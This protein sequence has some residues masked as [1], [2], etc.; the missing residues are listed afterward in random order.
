MV[1]LPRPAKHTTTVPTTGPVIHH[2]MRY[3]H[4]RTHQNG[5]KVRRTRYGPAAYRTH[6]DNLSTMIDP[7]QLGFLALVVII[8]W[9]Q[10]VT[11]FDDWRFLIRGLVLFCGASQT[12]YSLSR[13]ISL[14]H[15]PLSNLYESLIFLSW[16]LT[17]CVIGVQLDLPWLTHRV[18]RLLQ[19]GVIDRVPDRWLPLVINRSAMDLPVRH[20]MPS[21]AESSSNVGLYHDLFGAILM[22][23]VLIINL[24]AYLL[25]ERFKSGSDLVPALQ[26]NWL[27]MHVVVM[28]LSYGFLL[29]GCLFAIAYLILR[30]VY[31]DNDDS[32]DGFEYLSAWDDPPPESPSKSGST[33]SSD[34]PV[35]SPDPGGDGGTADGGRAPSSD[36][37]PPSSSGEKNAF[38]PAGSDG[39]P[40]RRMAVANQL[41][42]LAQ[43]C[44]NQSYR[45]IGLGF[46]LLTMGLLSGAVWANQ[47]WGSYWSWDPKETWA[48]ITWFVFAIYL[49]TRLS[50]GWS[51][52]KSAKLALVGFVSLWICY[53]G[54]NLMAKGLHSYGFFRG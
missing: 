37:R 15:F 21:W 10:L 45:S 51:G 50:R 11:L 39:I 28:I 34:D 12:F 17:T 9:V 48:L 5:P 22:P 43:T 36:E 53:L 41:Q 46:P 31:R 25:P 38:S 4:H 2:A 13:W 24:F 18:D 30:T 29:L 42:A 1:R 3:H 44:D 23:V 33:S 47:T 32:N 54:V 6:N 26:S 8:Y 27:Q 16:V 49:H 52:S 7:F 35:V 19:T 20:P 14:G 40:G